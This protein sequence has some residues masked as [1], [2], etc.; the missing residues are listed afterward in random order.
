[1]RLGCS[2]LSGV[3]RLGS[4]WGLLVLQPGFLSGIEASQRVDVPSWLEIAEA[5]MKPDWSA[6]D[7]GV[8]ALMYHVLGM[9]KCQVRK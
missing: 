2:W 8:K 6:V 7:S 5:S 3:A 9:S 1:M 4:R